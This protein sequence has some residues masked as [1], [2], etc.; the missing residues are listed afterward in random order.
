MVLAVTLDDPSQ[1]VATIATPTAI[2]SYAMQ[3]KKP[4]EVRRSRYT[5]PSFL[6]RHPDCETNPDLSGCLDLSGFGLHEV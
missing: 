4:G 5:T 2:S 3:P 1:P 6:E